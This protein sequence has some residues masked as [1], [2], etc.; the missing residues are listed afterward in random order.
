MTKCKQLILEGMS[1]SGE[2]GSGGGREG[3]V[4]PEAA[5]K[6]GLRHN[7]PSCWRQPV[8]VGHLNSIPS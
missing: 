8:L 2:E 6:V 1:G 3:V 4:R 5:H 7:F